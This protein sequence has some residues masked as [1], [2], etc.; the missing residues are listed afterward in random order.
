M[1]LNA[2]K[3]TKA[4]SKARIVSIALD[5]EAKWG[6]ALVQLTFKHKLSL[7]SPIYPW[8]SG[9]A[10]LDLH[11]G[12]DDITCD[13][14]W[15]H[16]GAKR[17]HNA[18]LREKGLLVHGTWITPA[19]IQS[20]LIEAGHTFRHI[21]AMLNPNDKQD[22]LLAY[23]LLRDIWSLPQLTSGAPGRIEAR[24]SLR[25]FGSMCYHFLVPYICV[26]LSIEDQLEYL[27]YAAHLALVL[28]AHENAC[29]NFLPSALYINLMIMV[30]NVFFCVAKA[31]IDTP[32]DDFSIV[33]LGTDCL[34][35][36]FGCLR[37]I[38]GNDS[39]VDNY[40]L[41]SHLTRTMETA[42]ILALHPEWDK[43]PRRLHL[44]TISRDSSVIPESADHI[45][46]PSWRASQCL[47]SITPPTVWIR[48]RRRLEEEHPF[49][50]SILQAIESIPNAT[51]LAP[52]GA[53]LIHTPASIDD[54]EDLSHD[55][56]LHGLVPDA[57]K[58]SD[59]ADIPLTGDGICELED[60]AALLDWDPE[61]HPFSNVI[62]I[63]D[64]DS[65]T[66]NKSRSLSMLFKYSKSTSSTDQLRRV[67]QQARYMQSEPETLVD[68]TSEEIGDVLMIDNPV[69]SLL[70]CEDNI[71]LC[72]GEVISMH[73]GSRAVDHLRLDVLLEDT[74]R[75]TYQAYSLVC[76]Q[77]N[78][79]TP[80]DSVHKYDWRAL[81]LLPLK[82][83]VPG[84]LIQPINPTL[85]MPTSQALFY[86]FETSTLIAF[87]SSLRDRLSKPQLKLIP[88]TVQTDRFPY[89]E[90]SGERSALLGIGH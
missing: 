80:S 16:V 7:S 41:G 77:P 75:I 22:V 66:I 3:G 71:F 11:V 23:T 26:D 36:L 45:S 43:A 2:I 29:S 72:I 31:K 24:D 48:G 76:T 15:K 1:A 63:N 14:D 70:S 78:D 85:A 37:T 68:D 44:L 62:T 13:K 20:H 38:V 58:S 50:R 81:S 89:R 10:L 65:G 79:D 40:Q 8:L 19:L 55:D 60:A 86:I 5:G 25:L 51:V 34:E 54:I 84:S 61:Q 83:K 52:F 87:A 47:S 73:V 12:D 39:N 28:Y 74:V 56:V 53:L 9:C 18:L 32:N 42:N 4:L 67:Q 30:K 59:H 49:V 57:T 33:L 46:P 27:S 35:N 88:Q 21:C 90:R 69:A 17:P 82:F 64:N 6:K